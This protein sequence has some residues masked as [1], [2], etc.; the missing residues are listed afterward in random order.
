MKNSGMTCVSLGTN[1]FLLGGPKRQHPVLK[2]HETDGPHP[3]FTDDGQLIFYSLHPDTD[4]LYTLPQ[5]CDVPRG[6]FSVMAHHHGRSGK[7]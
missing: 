1:D 3:T 4:S 5:S 2:I 6:H 7:V